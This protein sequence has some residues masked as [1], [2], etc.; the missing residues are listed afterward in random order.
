MALKRDFEVAL[1]LPTWVDPKEE[2]F[3][4]YLPT[5]SQ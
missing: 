1:Y 5:K 4:V 2:S 3:Y